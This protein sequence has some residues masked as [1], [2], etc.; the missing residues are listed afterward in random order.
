MAD[1]VFETVAQ[2]RSSAHTVSYTGAIC[3]LAQLA[4]RLGF[5]RNG[6]DPFPEAFLRN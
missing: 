3:V 6:S 5:Y 1:A 4:W 2:E